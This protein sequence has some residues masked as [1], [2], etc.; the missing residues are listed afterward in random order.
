MVD[1]DKKEHKNWVMVGCALNITKNG[2]TTKIQTEMETWYQ[3]LISSPPLQSLTCSC[4]PRAPKCLSCVTW[5]LE[6]TRHHT[7]KRSKICCGNSD[8]KQW[9]S[10]TGAWEVAKV[11][12]PILGSRKSDV[13]DANTTDIGGLLNLLEW[14]PFIKPPVSGKLLSLA[15]DECRN[16]WAHAPKQEL[17]DADVLTIFGHLNNLLSDPVFNAD[18][19]AQ[20]ASKELQDLFRHGLVNVRDSEVEALYLLRQSLVADLTKCQNDL[21][22]VQNKVG[23]LDAETTKV[24]RAVQK[25][26]SELK[27]QGDTNTEEIN[28]L[29]RELSSKMSTVLVAVDDF[30]R[31]LNEKDD[32][33]D[34]V[35]VIRDDVH[36]VRTGMRS[37]VGELGAT[38][39]QSSQ[40]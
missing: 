40:K 5:E 13:I 14:C 29:R 10:P 21:A 19:A 28:R 16:H 34:A 27:E 31:R 17:Q 11:F 20:N 8:R 6:L 7:S 24:N 39:K 33:K 26:L 38:W 30:N 22:D 2:I 36:N 32:L 9:G 35:E 23:Q 4:A 25:D 18:K 1:L 12:M 37:I 3:S 15:R